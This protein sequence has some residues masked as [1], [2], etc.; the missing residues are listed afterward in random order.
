MGG[1]GVPIIHC[2][3]FRRSTLRGARCAQGTKRN[4]FRATASFR[5]HHTFPLKGIRDAFSQHRRGLVAKL[6]E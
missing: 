3:P 6:G 5:V 2:C 4:R 1:G